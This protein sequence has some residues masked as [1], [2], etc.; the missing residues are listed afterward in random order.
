M[1][2]L[3]GLLVFS[4]D[5]KPSGGRKM[6]KL[7]HYTRI[8]AALIIIITIN[9]SM[10]AQQVISTVTTGTKLV[11][12]QKV[13]NQSVATELTITENWMANKSYLEE[14]KNNLTL[15]ELL[16]LNEKVF[17]SERNVEDWMLEDW[18]WKTVSKSDDDKLEKESIELEQWM[19][20]E[21]FWVL[22]EDKESCPLEDW[23]FNQTFWVLLE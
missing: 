13:S 4:I 3:F 5:I 19:F 10:S 21:K 23:M 2:H 12:N 18:I 20:D 15:S 7:V 6:K 17:E 11:M 1:H 22:E 14:H 8:L 16:M 9:G